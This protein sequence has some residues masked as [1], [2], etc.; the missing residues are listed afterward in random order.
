ML[1]LTAGYRRSLICV[2]NTVAVSIGKVDFRVR[3]TAELIVI[4]TG[5][6]GM[7]VLLELTV[8]VIIPVTVVYGTTGCRDTC[9]IGDGSA[10]S[11]LCVVTNRTDDHT[12]VAVCIVLIISTNVVINVDLCRNVTVF[13]CDCV[14]S[15]VSAAVNV[16][17]IHT[18][19]TTTC[20]VIRAP[21]SRD[22]ISIIYCDILKCNM[23]VICSA[24][25]TCDTD[26]TAVTGIV[27]ARITVG[28]CDI[29]ESRVTCRICC[30]Y[31]GRCELTVR[32][33]VRYGKVLNSTTVN[34]AEHTHSFLV[35]MSVIV[36]L[37]LPGV[38]VNVLDCM[39]VTIEGAHKCATVGVPRIGNIICNGACA[40]TCIV[41]IFVTENE[42]GSI[43]NISNRNCAAN[44][45]ITDG[46]EDNAVISIFSTT[47]IYVVKKLIVLF[48]I[49]FVIV[50]DYFIQKCKLVCICDE[51]RI[52]F[53]T[54]T[55]CE[56]LCNG[57]I[58]SIHF[59]RLESN[60][61]EGCKVESY[62]TGCG[63][64]GEA[65]VNRGITCGKK[66]H[67][68]CLAVFYVVEAV[69]THI[70]TCGKELCNCDS[71]RNNV[72]ACKTVDMYVVGS[73]FLV[74][75]YRNVSV[76]IFLFYD[77]KV[78]EA[79]AL[80][81]LNT[82]GKCGGNVTCL[83]AHARLVS[84][85]TVTVQGDV[86]RSN[87]VSDVRKL[88]PLCIVIIAVVEAILLVVELCRI[89]I[90]TECVADR[91]ALVLVACALLH[92]ESKTNYDFLGVVAFCAFA[93]R[94]NNSTHDRTAGSD[95]LV[96]CSNSCKATHIV[97]GFGG[98]KVV[99]AC[100][101]VKANVDN[102]GK[103]S[104]C[105][106]RIDEHLELEGE[107][108]IVSNLDVSN[109]GIT[110]FPVVIVEYR[111]GVRAFCILPI[112]I[113]SGPVHADIQLTAL[114][115]VVRAC[116]LIGEPRECCTN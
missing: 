76:A 24:C 113:I 15:C 112:A 109:L 71:D 56:I 90:D 97:L 16:T 9:H 22:L 79:C 58:P 33:E 106:C 86:G 75:V 17:T 82:L 42:L 63:V 49:I 116:Y 84:E 105:A 72:I 45:V 43:G 57:S 30:D 27:N 89:E 14:A 91:S 39:T 4:G 2:N 48:A 78:Y 114:D 70:K 20:Y 37:H 26:D 36:T 65:V 73:C 101:D 60:L 74:I 100:Y 44:L 111:L 10:I 53:R 41:G 50:R 46:I 104:N 96:E 12:C 103:L 29:F 25:A 21:K 83:I 107:I 67:G 32:G 77:R 5:I 52:I 98:Y 47:E 54:C 92:M 3:N 87:A 85:S 40:T 23:I 6:A 99:V 7:T 66:C 69:V 93:I 18:Y 8:V 64:V 1:V 80:L 110:G 62:V 13:E 94:K 108:A 35:V 68:N 81:E 11:T 115:N 31:T 59:I 88:G 38:L 19:K 51:V 95:K 61:R 34:V 102:L 55:A 28:N